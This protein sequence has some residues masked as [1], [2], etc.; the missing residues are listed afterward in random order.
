MYGLTDSGTVVHWVENESKV[1]G[2]YERLRVQQIPDVFQQSFYFVPGALNPSDNGTRLPALAEQIGPDSIFFKGAAW[3][4]KGIIRAEAEGIIQHMS[5]FV[6]EKT[7][8][9]ASEAL[10]SGDVKHDLPQL[11]DDS[12]NDLSCL[13]NDAV[14]ARPKPEDNE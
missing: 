8:K 13:F 11:S 7:S 10:N 12:E 4:R 2:L 1:F 9:V 5:T 6:K 3:M 14:R